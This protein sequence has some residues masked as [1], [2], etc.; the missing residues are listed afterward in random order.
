LIIPW[1]WSQALVGK[2]LSAELGLDLAYTPLSYRLR[3]K[4]DAQPL[5]RPSH[6]ELRG[7]LG[8]AGHF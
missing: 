7:G 4:S 6:F 2:N 8:V 1:R 5:A 3:Y